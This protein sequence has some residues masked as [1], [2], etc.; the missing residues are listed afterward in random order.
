ME[1]KLVPSTPLEVIEKRQKEFQK[2]IQEI[3]QAEEYC[4]KSYEGVSQSWGALLEDA[5]LRDIIAKLSAA[6][7]SMDNMW[8][9]LK[10]LPQFERMQKAAENKTLHQQ[11]NKLRLQQHRRK[12]HVDEFQT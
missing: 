2:F 1:A 9:S 10:T 7:E 11:I 6:E 3:K 4:A 12:N 5:R 8:S